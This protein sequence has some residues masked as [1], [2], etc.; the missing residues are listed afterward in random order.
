MPGRPA[1]KPEKNETTNA[2]VR[3]VFKPSL[4]HVL[5]YRNDDVIHRFLG[6]YDVSWAEA[7]EL[8]TE[9]KKWLWL[10]TQPAPVHL[11][12]IAPMHMMDEMWHNFVLFTRDYETFCKEYLGRFAHHNP[13]RMQDRPRP[14]RDPR[15]RRANTERDLRAAL[16]FIYDHLGEGTLWKWHVYL[17]SRYGPEFLATKKKVPQFRSPSSTAVTT[18]NPILRA[19]HLSHR[20]KLAI[21]ALATAG[22]GR[23]RGLRDA[24]QF[25][26]LCFLVG[27]IAKEEDVLLEHPEAPGPLVAYFHHGTRPC[28]LG[29]VATAASSRAKAIQL[30]RG[31]TLYLDRRIIRETPPDAHVLPHASLKRIWIMPRP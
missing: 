7:E 27:N 28:R 25:R 31:D 11:P 9:V 5:S 6:L 24:D 16:V 19:P 30:Q 4:T 2:R 1:P 13:T 18:Q 21:S 12:I 8:F 3:R 26:A 22:Y 17:P 20:A 14:K 23:V 15:V 29:L 10:N